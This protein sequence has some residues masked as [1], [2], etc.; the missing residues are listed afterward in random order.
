MALLCSRDCFEF[1]KT[2]LDV[3]LFMVS[4]AFILFTAESDIFVNYMSAICSLMRLLG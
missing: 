1:I 3:F 4:L 2:F